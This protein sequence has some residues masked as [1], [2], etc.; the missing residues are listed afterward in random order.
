MERL[1][2]LYDSEI[3]FKISCFW[4][5][6]ID[7]AIGDDLNTYLAKGTA[8]SIHDAVN[9][10]CLV[11]VRLYPDSTFAAGVSASDNSGEIP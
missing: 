11:A 5:G 4:D 6:G 3:N 8:A 9:E 2:A 1:Q 7:W 10:L